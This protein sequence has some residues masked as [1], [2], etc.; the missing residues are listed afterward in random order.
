VVQ[1]HS[2]EYHNPAQIAAS[3]VLVVG[4]ANSG[5]QIAADLSASHQVMLSRG[6]TIRRMPRRVLGRGLHWWGDHLGLIAAPLDSWRG[7]HRGVTS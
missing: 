1:L 7:P 3:K 5:V 6:Q 4:A 2:D